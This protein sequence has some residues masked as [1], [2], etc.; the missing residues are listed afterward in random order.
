VKVRS[1]SIRNFR[2]I[3]ELDLDFVDPR[4]GKV[5]DLICLIGDNGS[6]KT[7]V[8]QA[9]A[10]VLS[11]ATRKIS[12]AEGMKW[13]GFLSERMSSLGATRIALEMEFTDSEIQLVQDLYAQ[14]D[15]TLTPDW[16]QANP[17]A[18]FHPPSENRFVQVI[19]DQGRLSSS[20]GD[21]GISQFM[22]R[23]YAVALLM[24]RPELSSL[25]PLCGGVFWFDQF[26]NLGTRMFFE[27]GPASQDTNWAN[28]VSQLRE[29]LVGMWGFHTSPG[30][31]SGTDYLAVLEP[32]LELIFPRTRLKGIA[33]RSTGMHVKAS[34]FYFLIERD[35]Q[36]FDIA[37]MSS[38]EQA[39]FSLLYE[40]VRLDIANSVVLIDE[41]ELHL[42]PPQQQALL[43][44][45][46]VIGP[47]CQFIITTHSP[48]LTDI[49]PDE[50]EIRLPG[51][52][53]CL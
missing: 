42:H 48:Y 2:G 13:H 22:A 4:T 27:Q 53:Q 38:G 20:S 30:P 50:Q 28:G 49:I 34:D 43:G 46:N 18:R 5:R 37:E 45:L 17:Q 10:L 6:G 12:V 33:P 44:M 3:K 9:I 32:R 39:V 26:R 14:V 16:R 41:L 19:F 15:E 31:K 52:R 23:A 21:E 7:T 24:I 51:G 11:L 47:D 40:F 25:L 1:V 36:T 8:L 29:F 35:G